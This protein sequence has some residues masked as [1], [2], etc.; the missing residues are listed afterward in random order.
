MGNDNGLS[1]LLRIKHEV[2]FTALKYIWAYRQRPTGVLEGNRC[3]RTFI[4]YLLNADYLKDFCELKLVRYLIQMGLKSD[5]EL[6]FPKNDKLLQL[7]FSFLIDLYWSITTSQY[8]VS[9]CRT[10]K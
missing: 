4:L 3:Y 7:L 2:S 5:L 1:S 10:T 8:C 6:S 9:L